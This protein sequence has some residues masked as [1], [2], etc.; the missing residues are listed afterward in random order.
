M[1]IFLRRMA[2]L[3][4]HLFW[5]RC[6]QKPVA[7]LLPAT[8]ES[9]SSAFLLVNNSGRDFT[10]ATSRLNQECLAMTEGFLI[11]LRLFD[12]MVANA[13]MT[14]ITLG[15]GTYGD[16]VNVF[17]QEQGNNYVPGMA[18]S[19][20]NSVGPIFG[21]GFAWFFPTPSKVTWLTMRLS[22]GSWTI[23][24]ISTGFIFRQRFFLWW[25]PMREL[26]WMLMS[27]VCKFW[28]VV[29]MIVFLYFRGI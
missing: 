18:C 11:N 19:W 10:V 27:K 28:N 6:T 20:G 17:L 16:E 26:Q 2:L 12:W 5:A 3:S 15:A 24:A 9:L 21:G 7:V 13:E 8:E 14:E 22:S 1:C 23:P 25:C 29:L 4:I